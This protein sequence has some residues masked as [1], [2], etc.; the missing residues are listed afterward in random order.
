MD[1]PLLSRARARLK[2]VAVLAQVMREGFPR[3]FAPDVARTEITLDGV[4]GDLY[5]RAASDPAVLLIPGAAPRGKDDPRAVRLALAIARAHRTVFVPVLDLAEKRF[6]DDDLERIATATVALSE[7]TRHKVVHVGISYG[8]SL[9]LIAASDA[10]RSGRIAMVATFGAYFDLVGLI[11]AATTRVSTVGEER[12][13]WDP[14]PRAREALVEVA[15]HAVST[16]Q[17][18]TLHRALLGRQPASEL[19]EE[20]KAV[21]DLVTN[22]DPEATFGL[23]ARLHPEARAMLARFSPASVAER[24][25]VP[26]IALHAVDDPVTPFG[27]ARRLQHGLSGARL[28]SVRLFDHVDFEGASILKAVPDLY[29]LWRFT[30]WVLSAQE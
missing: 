9:S 27:E 13:S 4:V 26:V 20:A 5:E 3:P 23:A 29:R 30:S 18:E 28:L 1:A 15:L 11:Q 2:A 22:E 17:R 7:R 16:P 12:L 10:R 25:H 21:Y 14:H 24:I 6:T 8:G 19:P